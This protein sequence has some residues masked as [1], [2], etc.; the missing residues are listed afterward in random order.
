MARVTVEDCLDNVDNRFELVLAGAK[1]ARQL[2]KGI[3]PLVDWENDK[4]TVV[5]LR[6]IA[7]GHVTSEILTGA[8]D[9]AAES[10]SLGGF[11]AADV[12]AEVGGGP[13]QPDPGASQERSFDESAEDAGTGSG[14][15]DPTT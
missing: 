14:D 9:N 6:E 15:S 11:S 3:E 8:E 12:E 5:A 7:A 1:R 2:A 4:P 10:L 13:V